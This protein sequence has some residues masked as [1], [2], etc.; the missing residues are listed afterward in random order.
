M[1]KIS[2]LNKQEKVFNVDL[3]FLNVHLFI[4]LYR[5]LYA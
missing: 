2:T 4:L 1:F 5:S 3:T